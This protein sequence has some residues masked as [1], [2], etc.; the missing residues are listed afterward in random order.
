MTKQAAEPKKRLKLGEVPYGP[1]FERIRALPRRPIPQATDQWAVE[2]AADLTRRLA[3][4]PNPYPGPLR[5]LQAVA[6]KEAWEVGGLAGLLRAGTGKTLTSYLLPAVLGAKRPLYVCPAAMEGDVAKEFVQYTHSWNG[7]KLHELQIV[8]YETFASPGNGEELSPAGE[9]L[10][11]SLIARMNPDLII[12]DE[13][14]RCSDSGT[15]TSRRFRTF[16]EDTTDAAVC[17]ITG[18]FFK[19]S[20][21]DGSHIYEW[22]LGD[23]AP[24][25]VDFDER[26]LWASYLDVGKTAMRAGVGAL[27][28]FLNSQERREYNRAMFDDDRRSIVRRAVARWCFETPGVLCTTEPRLDIPLYVHGLPVPVE[29]EEEAVE[30]AFVD[31]RTYE[32]RPD[33]QF[34]VDR[35]AVARA[36]KQL[37]YGFYG[38]WDPPPPADY[39]TAHSAWG[40]WCRKKIKTNQRNID[41]EARMKKA[42]RDKLYDKDDPDGRVLLERWQDEDEA[43][44]HETGLREPPSVPVWIAGEVFGVVEQWL[45]EHEGVI[46]VENIGIGERIAEEFSIPYYG[47]E[48]IDEKSGRHIKEH[49]GGSAVASLQAN[50]TG[51]N[52]QGFWNKNLWLCVPTEQGLAR[53]H[54]PGQKADAVHNWYVIGCAEHLKSFYYASNDKSRF[55]ADMN[56]DEQRLCYAEIDMPKERELERRGGRRWVLPEGKEK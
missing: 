27:L 44:Q 32:R 24:L 8:S 39:S 40:K 31:L 38:V 21:K 22:A 41:S 26:E 10:L 20:I 1:E 3:K 17:A 30:A 4:K 54:R 28:D 23:N 55:A 47:A 56:G 13:S 15:T 49:P 12:L 45:G 46:W 36:A 33:G 16:L 52:L 50:G 34:L 53:T 25:P 43:Y 9:V 14:H 35:F 37:G 7:P 6:L 11:Q 42:V 29:L 5:P 48:G 18:T 19:T 2:L 51:R